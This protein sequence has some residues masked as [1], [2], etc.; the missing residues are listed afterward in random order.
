L[1]NSKSNWILTGLEKGR[2]YKTT[3]LQH[4][5]VVGSHPLN[6]YDDN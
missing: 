5:F 3:H 1:L 2:W 4:L 6:R